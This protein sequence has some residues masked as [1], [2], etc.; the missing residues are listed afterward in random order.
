MIQSCPWPI[1]LLQPYGQEPGNQLTKVAL[2]PVAYLNSTDLGERV[3]QDA[4]GCVLEDIWLCLPCGS[5]PLCPSRDGLLHCKEMPVQCLQALLQWAA[6]M[7]KADAHHKVSDDRHMTPRGG[8]SVVILP[9]PMACWL[10]TL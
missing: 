2:L 9:A 3:K 6:S 5:G 1:L 10:C 7:G 4:L 8:F